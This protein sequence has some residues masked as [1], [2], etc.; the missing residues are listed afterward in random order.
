MQKD[1]EILNMQ[2]GEARINGLFKLYTVTFSQAYKSL[3]LVSI[4]KLGVTELN[5]TGIM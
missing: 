1:C 5:I 4:F 2:K 3:L